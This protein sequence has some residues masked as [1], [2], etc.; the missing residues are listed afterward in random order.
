MKPAAVRGHQVGTGGLERLHQLA[1]F[2]LLQAA[3][4]SGEAHQV[5][6]PDGEPMVDHLD[7]VLGPHDPA[8]GRGELPPPDIDEELL[9]LGQEQLD[10]RIGDLRTGQAGV[11][12]LGE[13]LQEG[14]DLPVGEAGCGLAG[15]TGDLDGH[16]LTQQ[17]GL[18]KTGEAAQG[19]HI[20]LGEGLDLADVGEAH[21]PPEAGREVHGD[22]RRCGPPGTACSGGRR[23][24]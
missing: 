11:L 9:Q 1:Q 15:G 7:V 5:R 2:L 24:G 12:G 23:R 22:S 21:G 18:D 10:Q 4:Q 14:V 19:Q 3:G 6:E 20:G 8:G 13:A 16:G 17:A